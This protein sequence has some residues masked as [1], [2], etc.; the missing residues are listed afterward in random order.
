MAEHLRT[1]GWSLKANC[2]GLP[3][4]SEKNRRMKIKTS[5]GEFASVILPW[6]H[7]MC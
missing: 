6:V 1:E 2:N 7:R 3:G 4:S 5:R